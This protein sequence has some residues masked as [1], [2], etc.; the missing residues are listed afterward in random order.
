MIAIR[1]T[2]PEQGMKTFMLYH[3]CYSET[4]LSP[5][6]GKLVVG[7]QFHCTTQY[8]FLISLNC[9]FHEGFFAVAVHSTHGVPD[10]GVL[11]TNGKPVSVVYTVHITAMAWSLLDISEPST[12]LCK[13][14]FTHSQ[15]LEFL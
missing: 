8:F 2:I 1:N 12:F 11:K 9:S 6:T 14:D 3:H 10:L 4:I 15:F 7:F 13:I 5:K